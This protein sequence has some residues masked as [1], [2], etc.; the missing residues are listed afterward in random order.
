[1]LPEK[2]SIR[3]VA[4]ATGHD[5]NTICRWFHEAAEHVML[6]NEY[7]IRNLHLKQAQ[8]DEIWCFYKTARKC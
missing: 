3:G 7:Y 5:K 8:V 4:R 6:V 2:G 1:M